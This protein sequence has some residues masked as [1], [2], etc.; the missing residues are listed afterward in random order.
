[1]WLE[2]AILFVFL[3]L[4]LATPLPTSLKGIGV[5]LALVYVL[6]VAFRLQLFKTTKSKTPQTVVKSVWLKF[7]LF[8]VASSLY[9]YFYHPDLFFM[10]PKSNP[11]MWLGI[12]FVY[13]FLSVIP[14]EWLY[15]HFYIERYQE[16]FPQP[17]LFHLLNALTFSLAHLFLWNNLVLVLTFLGGVLFF[18]T[19]KKSGSFRLLCIE[20]ALYGLWL[21]TIG[22]GE[23]LA[24][25]T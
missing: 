8:A 18:D 21:F 11:L 14:Q 12:L 20:H 1:M 13:T 7:A 19:Y 16:L 10:V 5:T 4:S 9:M 24:F 25:P 23:M 15:R 2:W 6:T 22:A 17:W 3:P